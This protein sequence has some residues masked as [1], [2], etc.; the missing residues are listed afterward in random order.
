MLFRSNHK[1]E[2]RYAVAVEVM[3]QGTYSQDA[4]DRRSVSAGHTNR[5]RSTS[6]SVQMPELWKNVYRGESLQSARFSVDRAV[7]GV[8]ISAAEI[9]DL[10]VGYRGHCRNP[11][12]HGQKVGEDV[13]GLHHKRMGSN[14]AKIHLQTLLSGS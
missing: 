11:L 2:I 12:K 4:S 6:A 5:L 9:P 8:N 1:T 3:S 10:N 14:C 13:Y 7:C